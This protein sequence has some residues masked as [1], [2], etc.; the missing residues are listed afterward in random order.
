LSGKCWTEGIWFTENDVLH[1]G[2]ILWTLH[3]AAVLPKRVEDM[4][5]PVINLKR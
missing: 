1:V 2:M 4:C 5:D 3:I